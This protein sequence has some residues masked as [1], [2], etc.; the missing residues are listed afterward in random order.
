MDTSPE[1]GLVLETER[2]T[3]TRKRVSISIDPVEGRS[4]LQWG[5]IVWYLTCEVIPVN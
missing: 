1:L 5:N 3:Q 2:P 4:K